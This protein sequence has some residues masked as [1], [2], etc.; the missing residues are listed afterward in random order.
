MVSVTNLPDTPS[1]SLHV[2]VTVTVWD[3]PTGL[4]ADEGVIAQKHANAEAGAPA[5]GP[6][7][8]AGGAGDP[9][10]NNMTNAT[11]NTSTANHL[12]CP[13]VVGLCPLS[14]IRCLGSWVLGLCHGLRT[15]D[16][17]PI[18]DMDGWMSFC[19]FISTFL[20]SEPAF[21]RVPLNRS[22]AG[23]NRQE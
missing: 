18:A 2:Y 4:V 21:R 11:I 13:L 5:A 6:A 23:K 10:P 17:G 9:A 20:H 7:S 12:L 19:L 8:A 3:V 14:V 22:S 16:Q 1:P 15:T